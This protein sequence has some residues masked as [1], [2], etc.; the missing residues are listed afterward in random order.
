MPPDKGPIVRVTPEEV[1]ICDITAAKEI[2]KTGGRF[3]KSNFYHALAPPGTES[4][5]S[6]TDPAFHS[7]HRRLLAM[8]ISDSSLTGFE[9]VIAGKVHLAVR[10]MGEEMRSRGAMDVFKWWLF[11]ATDVIGELSFG[12]SFRMLE[13]GQKNQYILDLEQ[14][15][16]L[17]PVR[18]TFP[19]LVQLGSLLPLP[20]FRRVAAAGQRLID[21][22]QQ[23]I[24]RYARLVEGSGVSAPPPTLFMKLYN[25]GKDGLSTTEIRNEARTYIVAGSDTTAISLTYLVYAVCRDE[26]VHARLVDEVAAL[27]ENFDDRMMR[28]LP[29]LNWVINEA[30]R[31]YTAVPFGLPRTVPAEGAEFL[32]YRL[33]GGVIVSTQSYSLHRDGEI[34]PEPDR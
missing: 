10:R 33:P 2:H 32:G 19:L 28:E 7:A 15:S 21:Y 11:M 26:R 12:E 20:V 24:D 5:F 25:A 31:L 29:Y 1:D 18:T 9:Q 23:S 22:A 34:F 6:T 13:S 4:V 8:P 30:L 14:I 27:P 3:L 17:A 16:S